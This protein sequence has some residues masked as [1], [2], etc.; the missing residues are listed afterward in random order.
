VVVTAISKSELENRAIDN[1]DD[2]ARVVPQLMIGNQGGS[3]QGGNISI[4]GIA[5][6]DS[7]PFGDQAVSSTVWPSPS[8]SCAAWSIRISIRSRC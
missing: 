2:I 4:R 5:G 6:P 8:R 3:V 7:N 1:L